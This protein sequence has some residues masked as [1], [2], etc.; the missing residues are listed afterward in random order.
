M[1]DL[2][3]AM[4]PL[5][6]A[7]VS[8]ATDAPNRRSPRASDDV[9]QIESS[10]QMCVNGARFIRVLRDLMFGASEMLRTSSSVLGV[11]C[12]IVEYACANILS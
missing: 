3:N 9:E 10:S 2:S 4:E 12:A 7:V 5:R 8:I 11:I 6:V 1:A